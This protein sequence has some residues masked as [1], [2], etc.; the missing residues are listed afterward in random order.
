MLPV[1]SFLAADLAQGEI[2]NTVNHGF[3]LAQGWGQKA[4][5]VVVVFVI[6]GAILHKSISGMIK[7]GAV[8]ILG[9]II[10]LSFWKLSQSASND[11]TTW[12]SMPAA[13][14]GAPP[15]AT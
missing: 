15:G 4:I 10:A 8:V 11:V 5:I 2:E 6:A 13:G 1:L 12:G 7:I 3:N 9:G 14:H